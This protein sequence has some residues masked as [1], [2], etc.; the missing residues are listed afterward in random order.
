MIATW[1][2]RTLL[3]GARLESAAAEERLLE[4]L[5]EAASAL[6][7]DPMWSVLTTKAKRRAAAREFALSYTDGWAPGDAIVDRLSDA[8]MERPRR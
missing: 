4:R 8:A 7:Q 5:A 1:F 3:S 2:K 6:A